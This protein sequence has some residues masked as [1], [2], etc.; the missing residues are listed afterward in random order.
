MTHSSGSVYVKKEFAPSNLMFGVGVLLVGAIMMIV[1]YMVDNHRA[2]FNTII[3]FMFLMSIGLGSLFLV[4]LEHLVGAVWSVPFRR[5]SEM[6][7]SLIFIAPILSIPLFINLHGLFHWT[8]PE[9]LAED[10][11]LAAKAPYLNESFFIIRTVAIFVIMGIF[12]FLLVG[13]SFSQDK[14]K[15]EK[16]SKRNTVVSAIFMPFFAISVTILSI[17]WMMSL[18]PHWFSTIYG[19]Y[20][21]AGTFGAAMAV[22]AFI[23][24]NLTEGGYMPEKIKRDHYYNFGAL[25]FAFTN[26]WAY[27]AFSQFLLIWY[28]N[29][30]E[31]TFW[32]ISRGQGSWLVVSI[33]LIIIRFLVPYAVLL[34]QPAKSDAKRLKFMSIWIIFAHFYDLYWLIMPTYSKTGASFSWMELVPPVLAAGLIIVVF[35]LMSRKRNLIPIGD[36]KL[37][38]GLNFHL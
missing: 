13:S 31:E 14:T 4:A 7:A 25:L 38:R 37:S 34:P 35:N 15:S 19:V 22:L 26:F 29:L 10:M 27:I 16:I 2:A 18:E 24:I 30:P 8:H 33:F 28:S 3:T 9:A 1:A 12:Y 21:F 20:Y 36:P 6:L 5:I 32:Y 17:D 11:I 23:S